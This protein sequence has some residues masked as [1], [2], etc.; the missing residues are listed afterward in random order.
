MPAAIRVSP[1]SFTMRGV[2]R[3]SRLADPQ[4][5]ALRRDVAHHAGLEDVVRRGDDAAQRAIEAH[6]LDADAPPGSRRDRSGAFG[7]PLPSRVTVPPGDAVLREHD[8]VSRA[9]SAA[10]P[11]SARS[12]TGSTPLASRSPR[13]AVR[14]RPAGRSPRPLRRW[15][16]RPSSSVRPRARIAS[17][18]ATARDHRDLV[19]GRRRGA[20]HSFRRSRRRRRCRYASLLLLV[21]ASRSEPTKRAAAAFVSSSFFAVTRRR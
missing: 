12:P 5:V 10:S 20:S 11:M 14:D 8:G 4:H 2:W 13:P 7:R 18:W 15:S 16:R 19:A 17:R 3:S 6:H 1:Q 9:R 21:S